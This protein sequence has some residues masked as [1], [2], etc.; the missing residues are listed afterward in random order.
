M[1]LAKAARLGFFFLLLLLFLLVY[2]PA[3]KHLFQRTGGGG[4]C[5]V[6][7]KRRGVLKHVER[8]NHHSRVSAWWKL[9]TV[10]RV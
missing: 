4:V 10:M 5:P 9:Q 3:I 7:V 1:G 8:Q 6:P 2:P